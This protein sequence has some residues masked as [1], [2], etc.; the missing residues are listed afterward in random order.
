M[1]S[2]H[3]RSYSK[4]RNSRMKQKKKLFPRFFPHAFSTLS[5]PPPLPFPPPSSLSHF[6]R[7]LQEIHGFCCVDLEIFGLPSKIRGFL[8]SGF[9]RRQVVTL[10]IQSDK[11]SDRKSDRHSY[12][13]RLLGRR[14]LTLAAT[15]SF[16]GFK[17]YIVGLSPDM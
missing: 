13:S 8:E 14:I 10:S 4:K 17:R 9:S 1:S 3:A 16:R 15:S 11:Y 5:P 6:D 2:P 7:F 12:N